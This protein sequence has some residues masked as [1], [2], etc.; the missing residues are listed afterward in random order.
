MNH[1]IE[2]MLDTFEQAYKTTGD[3][4]Y[5][6]EVASNR[7]KIESEAALLETKELLLEMKE[8]S[9]K[10]TKIN[11]KRFIIQ[12]V[13]TVSSLIVATI[14]ATAAVIAIM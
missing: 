1:S 5:S 8:A 2:R 11:Q 12:T 9:M 7:H 13:L 3:L 10:E 14:A 6:A 4:E